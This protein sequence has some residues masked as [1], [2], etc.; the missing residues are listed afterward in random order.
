MNNV[1]RVAHPECREGKAPNTTGEAWKAEV[2]MSKPRI[3]S[4]AFKPAASPWIE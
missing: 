4:I 1:S 2:Y 3:L